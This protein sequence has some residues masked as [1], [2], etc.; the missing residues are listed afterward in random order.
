M[1]P[2]KT[3]AFKARNGY[4]FTFNFRGRAGFTAYRLALSL[5]YSSGAN[6]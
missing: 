6:R 2:P 5:F 1:K 4:L 3:T